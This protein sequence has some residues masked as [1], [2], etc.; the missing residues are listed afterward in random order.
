MPCSTSAARNT[1]L[2][3]YLQIYNGRMVTARKNDAPAA[4]Q[5]AVTNLVVLSHHDV[6]LTNGL[7]RIE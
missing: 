3:T 2:P 1:L 6:R 4:D 7:R 5:V